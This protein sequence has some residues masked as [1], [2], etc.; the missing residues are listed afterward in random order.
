MSARRLI[1][2][3]QRKVIRDSKK[4]RNKDVSKLTRQDLDDLIIILS[5]NAGIL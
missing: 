3:R 5:K 2:E 4:F 1:T